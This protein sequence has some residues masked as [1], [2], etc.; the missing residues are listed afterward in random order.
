MILE[1]KQKNQ[2]NKELNNAISSHKQEFEGRSRVCARRAVA[3]LIRG[4]L[5]NIGVDHKKLNDLDIINFCFK[6]GLLPGS[7]EI[8]QGFT[9][10]VNMS[11]SLSSGKD[12]I[13]SVRQVAQILDITI[14][15]NTGA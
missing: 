11:H 10:K 5:D 7:N 15:E 9:E 14:N 4:Y 3:I 2:F 8:L 6:E 13:E 12:L 1:Q